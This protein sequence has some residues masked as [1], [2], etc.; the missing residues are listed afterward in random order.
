MS[1]SPNRDAH[2]VS[3]WRS[4][5]RS[6]EAEVD[7]RIDPQDA[8]PVP[9][10]SNDEVV[11]RIRKPTNYAEI[12]AGWVKHDFEVT[13][14]LWNSFQDDFEELTELFV[15]TSLSKIVNDTEAFDNSL[16]ELRAGISNSF[17]KIDNIH[18]S[19]LSLLIEKRNE[20]VISHYRAGK[21]RSRLEEYRSDCY[22]KL[23]YI[24]RAIRVIIGQELDDDPSKLPLEKRIELLDEYAVTFPGAPV[25]PYHRVLFPELYLRGVE[26][27]QSTET[28]ANPP[29]QHSIS[30]EHEPK[31]PAAWASRE[32]GDTPVTFIRKHYGVW[33]DGVWEPNGLTRADLRS[34]RQ[35]YNALVAHER[36]HPDDKLNLPTRSEVAEAWV[37]RVARGEETPQTALEKERFAAAIRR[38]SKRGDPGID[39]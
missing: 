28:H 7:S 16:A 23:N 27:P 11:A 34:D 26:P 17:E 8:V 13:F 14:I 2:A 6:T 10:S 39:L 38:R 12:V 18:T 29:A 22:N 20:G 24:S 19:C 15:Y 9:P 5:S 4:R 1:R 3:H 33:H 32:P 31:Q 37:D 30:Q 36:R 25:S 35:L 21:T